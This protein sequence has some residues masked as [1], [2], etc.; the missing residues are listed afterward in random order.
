MEGP[1]VKAMAD[2]ESSSSTPCLRAASQT[3][4]SCAEIVRS[5]GAKADALL[6]SVCAPFQCPSSHL[7]VA[8]R[9]SSLMRTRTAQSAPDVTPASAI[10][11][12]ESQSAT[13]RANAPAPRAAAAAFARVGTCIAA[14]TSADVY[15]ASASDARARASSDA[16]ASGPPPPLWAVSAA[17][18]AAAAASIASPSACTLSALSCSSLSLS[19]A[20]SARICARTAVSPP[21]SDGLVMTGLRSGFISGV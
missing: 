10:R 19:A 11:S 21:R 14:S 5:D 12:A 15:V 18:A 16:S 1:W 17:A 2:L 7:A 3:A 8:R 9:S 20:R 6:R 13:Q 4:R